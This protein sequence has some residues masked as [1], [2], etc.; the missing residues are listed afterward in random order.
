MIDAA[1]YL[2]HAI[3]LLDNPWLIA[4]H[5]ASD[6]A[7]AVAF[8]AI[9]GALLYF[10]TNR[11][12][13]PWRAVVVWFAVFTI[14]CGATHAG[15]ILNLWVPVYLFTGL[16][17]AATAVLSWVTLVKLLPIIPAALNLPSLAELERLRVWMDRPLE[18]QQADVLA[19]MERIMEVITPLAGG[20]SGRD[21]WP[22]TARWRRTDDP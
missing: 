19:D 14:G 12:D 5:V 20:G 2:P 10:T 21:L 22:L 1:E 8:A 16:V 18:A 13:L 11:R 4:L 6:M 3:C 7:I 17:S 9:P 15:K